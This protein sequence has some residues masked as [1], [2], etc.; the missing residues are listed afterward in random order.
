[1]YN[2]GGNKLYDVLYPC[3]EEINPTIDCDIDE[4][5]KQIWKYFNERMDLD[6]MLVKIR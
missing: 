6:T 2:L 3:L 5:W 4:V 1:M